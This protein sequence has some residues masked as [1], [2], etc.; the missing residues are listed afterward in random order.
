ML[1]CAL[2]YQNGLG[3]FTYHCLCSKY[4]LVINLFINHLKLFNYENTKHFRTDS[5]KR[6][7]LFSDLH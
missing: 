3:M 5:F 7:M 1:N 6:A 2:E 4:R